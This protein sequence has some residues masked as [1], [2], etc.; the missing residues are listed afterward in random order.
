MAAD[1]TPG[2][3][4]AALE[5]DARIQVGPGTSASDRADYHG[6]I[7]RDQ[8][9]DLKVVRDL[10]AGTRAMIAE[11][12][13]Y[14]PAHPK[15][16]PDD[17]RRRLARAKLFNAMA[18][19]VGGFTGMVFRKSPNLQDDVPPEIVEHAQ[20][21]DLR[22]QALEVFA[23]GV[24]EETLLAGHVFIHIDAPRAADPSEV[25]GSLAQ[26][27]ALGRRPFWRIVR[28]DSVINAQWDYVGGRPVLT[29]VVIHEQDTEADGTYGEREVDRFR[30][31]LPGGGL[32][33]E[34]DGDGLT[35]VDEWTSSV[36]EIPL[37]PVYANPS[38]PDFLQSVP[39]LMDLAWENIEHYQVRS[40]HR[41]ALGF[42]SIPLPVFI[43]QARRDVEWGANRA[44]FLPDPQAKAMLLESSGASI[45]E[46]RQ[47]LKDIELRMTALGLQHLVQGRGVQKT[48]E[49][50]RNQ[51]TEVWSS[52]AAM[53]RGL[54][55]GLENALQLHAKYLGLPDGGRL[56]VNKDFDALSISPQMAAQLLAMQERGV[57]TRETLWDVLIRGEVLPETFDPEQEGAQL[58]ASAM[59]EITRT[60]EVLRAREEAPA[61]E[62]ADG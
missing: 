12:E 47:E 50:D 56:Q 16:D 13:K 53:A 52:L 2:L 1:Y 55:D 38:N 48:A 41:H 5:Q 34:R 22:G 40:D 46:S 61:E 19:T 15:E 9:D 39:P 45:A 11:G 33:W 25:N 36:D 54:R 31:L 7:W 32:L 60:L 24:F 10:Y 3:R 62:E 21:I 51:R 29:R 8:I 6:S 14:L 30:E 18:R 28:K 27:A 43:G 17:Y 42:A 26:I 37:V 35:L 58:D 59:D 44:I 23:R 49:E 4:R 20:N 57:I